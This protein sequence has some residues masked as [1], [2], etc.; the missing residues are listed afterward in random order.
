MYCGII[1]LF[2]DTYPEV[3][4]ILWSFMSSCQPGASVVGNSGGLGIG[5]SFVCEC[6][7]ALPRTETMLEGGGSNALVMSGTNPHNLQIY[8]GSK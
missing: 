3:E 4:G 2:F 8:G 6:H 1:M 7:S 5:F